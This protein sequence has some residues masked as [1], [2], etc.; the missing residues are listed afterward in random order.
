MV[1]F[2]V[3]LPPL[4]NIGKADN[5]SNLLIGFSYYVIFGF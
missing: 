5:K 2:D 4:N 1:T 3:I